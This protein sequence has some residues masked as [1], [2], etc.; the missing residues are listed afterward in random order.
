MPRI[1]PNA[2]GGIVV[3][4]Q[5]GKFVVVQ[6]AG[7]EMARDSDRHFFDAALWHSE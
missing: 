5:R 2:G 6:D 3:E 1:V 4:H 7:D